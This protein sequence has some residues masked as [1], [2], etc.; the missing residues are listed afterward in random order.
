[1]SE[2][3]FSQTTAR[4]NED[5]VGN[6]G[7]TQNYENYSGLALRVSGNLDVLEENTRAMLVA[8]LLRNQEYPEL[9][10][11]I[12]AVIKNGE[13]TEHI[14]SLP[15]EMGHEALEFTIIPENGAE[16]VIILAQE[17]HPEAKLTYVVSCMRDELDPQK[18]LSAAAVAIVH[19]MAVD[20]C[21][22]YRRSKDDEFV[23]VAEH[24][25]SGGVELEGRDI[26]AKSRGEPPIFFETGSSKF[27]GWPTFYRSTING[28]IG[29]CSSL[30][31]ERWQDDTITLLSKIA[32]QLGIANEQLTRH[33]RILALSRTD[34]LTG[35]LN[36][37]AFFEEELPRRILRLQRNKESAALFYIDLDNF[38][39]VN[40]THGHQAG[41]EVILKT[42]NL[43]MR[44]SRPGD[45]VARLGGDEFA[46]WLDGVSHKVAEARARELITKSHVMRNLTGEKNHPFGISAGVAM[47]NPRSCESLDE[48]ISRADAAMYTIKKMGK[49]GFKMAPEVE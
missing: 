28:A 6:V 42:R 26:L 48:L 23:I 10:E 45:V 27:L 13:I 17:R 1:M 46:M 24:G 12:T 19:A 47:F 39:M 5:C 18:M 32:H 30:K 15:K 34:G 22:I 14:L 11:L 9:K 2:I 7:L 29:I 3:E 20:G 36:R 16:N 44:L 33:E 35:L 4:T 38:K 40:D 31:G 43:L 8:T 41:D 25:N 37:R 49:G 21:K